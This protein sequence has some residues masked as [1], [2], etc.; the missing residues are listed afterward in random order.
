MHF[1]SSSLPWFRNPPPPPRAQPIHTGEKTL[2]IE[3]GYGECICIALREWQRWRKKKKG[4][5]ATVSQSSRGGGGLITY[6]QAVEQGQF[7][8]H[9]RPA[10]ID[11]T[12]PAKRTAADC[13]IKLQRLGVRGREWQR[14]CESILL[15]RAALLKRR[16]K[17]S[18]QTHH[19]K[20]RLQILITLGVQG[21]WQETCRHQNSK[22]DEKDSGFHWP[23]WCAAMPVAQ[24][25]SRMRASAAQ[26]HCATAWRAA[27]LLL[28]RSASGGPRRMKARHINT[29]ARCGNWP[30]L[31]ITEQGSNSNGIAAK[32]LDQT[33]KRPLRRSQ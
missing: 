26:R 7:S 23:E 14:Q 17:S 30:E 3:M 9:R 15:P 6:I 1:H 22:T 20:I 8:F 10:Y 28:H 4:K 31:S 13:F 25:K 18:F 2:K 27:L 32:W 21:Y 5:G 24:T 29:I 16:F 19:F 11:W 33:R 12:P